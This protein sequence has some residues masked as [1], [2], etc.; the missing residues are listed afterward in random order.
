LLFPPD[1]NGVNMRNPTAAAAAA[2]KAAMPAGGWKQSPATLVCLALALAVM[3]LGFR[4][5]TI[6]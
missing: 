2:T 4:I 3:A 1:G 5:A 6:W